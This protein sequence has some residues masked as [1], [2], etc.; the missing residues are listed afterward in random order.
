MK[1]LAIAA[2]ILSSSLFNNLSAKGKLN[3]KEKIEQVV[4]FENEKLAI[5][6]E[7]TEFVKVSFKID[8]LGKVQV[9]EANYSDKKI[10]D[11]LMAKLNFLE[12]NEQHDSEKVYYYHFT[13]KK[14]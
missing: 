3:I 8:E 6:K 2:V 10:N 13:F 14:R 4:K 9:L 5:T 11:Q 12:I 1:T 7:K